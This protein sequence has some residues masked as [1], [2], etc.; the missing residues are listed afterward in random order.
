M[1]KGEI[2]LLLLW[3]LRKKQQNKNSCF[4]DLLLL[5]YPCRKMFTADAI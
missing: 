3:F 5:F 4:I 2:S 1:T